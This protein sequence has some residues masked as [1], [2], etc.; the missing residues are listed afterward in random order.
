MLLCS[1]KIN[2][3]ES[4]RAFGPPRF[5]RTAPVLYILRSQRGAC[6]YLLARGQRSAAFVS[7]DLGPLSEFASARLP[8]ATRCQM[9]IPNEIMVAARDGDTQTVVRFLD[10]G[11]DINAYDARGTTLL[12]ECASS[13]H[14]PP[15]EITVPRPILPSQVE[16]CRVLVARGADLNERGRVYNADAQPSTPLWL[17]WEATFEVSGG[18]RGPGGNAAWSTSPSFEVCKILMEAGADLNA[19]VAFGYGGSYTILA[20]LLH[21]FGDGTPPALWLEAVSL[22]PSL[23]TPLDLRDTGII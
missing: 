4:R 8:Y 20:R 23:F 9:I 12:R 3:D 17:A 22:L 13:Y 10:E 21:D 1:S 5:T 11:G 15:F 14:K 7:C 2:S 19:L 6:L 18:I 16:L